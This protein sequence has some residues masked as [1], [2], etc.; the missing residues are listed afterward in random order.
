M[1]EPEKIP[2]IT[3]I[4]SEPVL[5][6]ATPPKPHEAEPPKTHVAEAHWLAWEEV[7]L[8]P[9]RSLWNLQGVH[10]GVVAKRTWNAFLEDNLLGHAAQLGYYFLFALFP[11]LVCASSILGLA[12]K[13]AQIFYVH[14]LHY[15]AEVIPPS[16]FGIVLAT[17][18]QTTTAS[19]ANK[20]TFG[21]IAAGWS[22]SVGMSAIQESLNA[23]YKVKETRSYW[24]ARVEAIGLTIVL[25]LMVT[26][27]L[28]ILLCGDMAAKHYRGRSEMGWL[29][30]S[31]SHTLSYVVCI[32]MIMLIFALVYYAAPNLPKR[33]WRWLTPGGA[34]GILG[35]FAA[36]AVL[37]LYLHFFDNFSVTY[38][39]LGAVIILMT[40]FYI[41]G[42]MLL[43]GAEINSEIEAAAME[44]KLAAQKVIPEPA[45]K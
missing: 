7:A 31:L 27:A 25:A 20:L 15:L 22:A 42:L 24:W 29:W 43:V 40:W 28:G 26:G 2:E 3:E 23:V 34:L 18:N 44:C 36:S 16:A 19:T 32:L 17:F 8:N 6:V 4:P 14:L 12:A 10:P 41:T 35:W 30:V 13:S 39:S 21:L 45:A 33:K 38:G 5:T 9:L 11:T 37:R 1:S